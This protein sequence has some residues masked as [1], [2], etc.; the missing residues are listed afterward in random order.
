MILEAT[1]PSTLESEFNPKISA[2]VRF[3]EAAGR[4]GLDEGMQKVLRSPSREI[5]VHIPIALDDGRLEVFTGYRV[6][7]SVARGP[8]KG[9]IRY[10]PDVSLD[11]VRALAAWMT[12][13]CAV[14]NLPFGGGKGGVICDPSL[15]SPSEIERITRRY[16]AELFE[17]IG[18]EKDVPAPDMNTNE[19]TMAWIMDTYSMHARHTQTA[20]VTGKPINLGGSRGRAEATGRGCMIVTEQALRKLGL[21]RTSTRVVIQGFGNVGGM[22]AKLMSR[23]G[24][25]IVC[26]IEYDGAVYNAKGLDIPALTKH[27]NETGSIRGFE[28]GEA[29][30]KTEAMF[31]ETDVLLPAAKENVI[32]SENAQRLRTKILCEGANGPTTHVADHI[33]S[34]KG[35]F[36]IPDILANAGGVTV[37]YFE[38]VQDRQGYFWNEQMVNDRL[39]EI[40]IN[41]FQDVVAY[42][43]KHSVNNRTAAYMLA[44]DRVA[45]AIKLRG[46]YA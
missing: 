12:W 27:R 32:T 36:V 37:S 24:F 25:K 30:D 1:M 11:E 13:K 23:A 35:I 16:T 19:Q 44:L 2:E 4:L 17:F 33:L 31:L 43:E 21:E 28:G 46:I 10:A 20:V 3:D 26:I 39:E 42:A 15:L 40:M 9:G 41:S 18:P 22:A 14:T 7:H 6:Q 8:A 45:Y 29:I 38:W 5:I 34:E